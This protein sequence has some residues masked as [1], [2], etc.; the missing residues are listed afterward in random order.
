ML[1]ALYIYLIHACIWYAVSIHCIML[2]FLVI[3]T[4]RLPLP[5]AIWLIMQNI[6]FVNTLDDKTLVLDMQHGITLHGL[7]HRY[8]KMRGVCTTFK[9]PIGEGRGQLI[10][11]FVL[12][13]QTCLERP[14]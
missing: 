9:L 14:L 7:L 12:H 6:F 2:F 8:S 5:H 4:A 10:S 1:Y 3:N 11:V 13:S